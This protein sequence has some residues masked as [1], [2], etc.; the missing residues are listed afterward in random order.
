MHTTEPS[1]PPRRILVGY[2]D[3]DGAKDAVALC[4]AI[5]P[6]DAYVAALDVLP[7]PG[8]PSSA[9]RLLKGTDFAE[10]E[11]YFAPAV[12]A[13][14][15]RQVDTYS[16]LGSSPA[17]VFES[18][19]LENAI[20]LIVVGSPHHG[21]IGR[22]LAGSVA[23]TLLHGAPV[24]VATAPHGYAGR[25]KESLGTIAV[26]YDGGEESQAALARA[27]ALVEASGAELDLL[28]VERPTA[29]VSGAIAYTLALPQDVE[30]IQRQALDEVGPS[31]TVRRRVLQGETAQALADA[32]S[33][34][35]DLI[36]V[37]SRGYGTVERVLLG[38]TSSV[39]IRESPC[40]V[41]VVP[42]PAERRAATPNSERQAAAS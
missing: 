16:Y 34:N 8:A 11:D 27:A 2:D 13:L 4:A 14:P 41:L 19:A 3:T 25:A 5:A 28:T 20:D 18:F 37:G 39:L 30:D 33:E 1:W 24:P 22:V 10:P 12:A 15:G 29:P 35:V 26:A 31:I 7:Y 38:S 9:F 32:C 6:A 40:P 42:R 17:R 23:Q 21:A 36:V